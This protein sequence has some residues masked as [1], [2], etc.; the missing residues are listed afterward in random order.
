MVE[1]NQLT[2]KEIEKMTVLPLNEHPFWQ[3]IDNDPSYR[4]EIVQ[5][6]QSNIEQSFHTHKKYAHKFTHLKVKNK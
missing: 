1:K 5:L 3:K 2:Q 6:I 4:E